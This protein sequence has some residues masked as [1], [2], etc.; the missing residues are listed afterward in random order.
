MLETVYMALLRVIS[1]DNYYNLFYRPSYRQKQWLSLHSTAQVA[2]KK[3][4]IK[5]YHQEV[6]WG[7]VHWIN[8]AEGKDKW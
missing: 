2:P 1:A 8:L 7:N 6:K 4:N 3:G 5:I